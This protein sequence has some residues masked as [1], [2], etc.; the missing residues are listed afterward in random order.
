MIRALLTF[1]LLVVGL[2][3]QQPQQR[4]KFHRHQVQPQQRRYDPIIHRAVPVCPPKP[5]VVVCQP[6]TGYR[7]VP[8]CIVPLRTV[9]VTTT[10]C[11]P[12]RVVTIY[13]KWN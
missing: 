2:D 13:Y 6:A 8:L 4:H 9:P 5:R 1:A 11:N 10:G 12:I 3:A 7:I